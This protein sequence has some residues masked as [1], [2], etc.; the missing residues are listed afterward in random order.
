MDSEPRSAAPTPSILEAGCAVPERVL[1][2]D[3]EPGI[4]RSIRRILSRRYRVTL[5]SSGTEALEVLAVQPHDLAIVDVRMPGMNGFEVLKEIK[6]S[7]PSMRCIALAD[8]VQQQQ[9][10]EA[11][12][13]DAVLIKGFPA[14]K[15][16]ATI[17]GLLSQEEKGG[18]H[19]DR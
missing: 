18:A 6:A 9:E 7:W 12:G 11:A 17:E 3:D 14:A 15:L 8:D 13:A 2:V 1:V 4:Q 19:A 16:V 5:A 10:A